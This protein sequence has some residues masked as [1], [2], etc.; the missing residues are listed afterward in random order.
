VQAESEVDR[1]RAKKP[2]KFVAA[3][4]D[5]VNVHFREPKQVGVM[6]TEFVIQL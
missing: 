2:L 4:Q 1:K 5:T 3:A 6:F